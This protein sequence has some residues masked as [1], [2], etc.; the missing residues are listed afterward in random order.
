[1]TNEIEVDESE[2][3]VVAIVI[4]SESVDASQVDN[5]SATDAGVS[6]VTSKELL[7]R[8]FAMAKRYRQEG[9][10][11]QAAKIFWSL[12]E[13]HSETPQAEAAK[14]ELL[15]LA[16]NYERA[17]N[18]HMARSIYEQLLSLED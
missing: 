3:T 2:Q 1:M 8:L 10:C 11:R 17:G 14:A 12:I 13:E 15:M 5:G 6:P 9:N 7:E 16:E 18:Q 4:T